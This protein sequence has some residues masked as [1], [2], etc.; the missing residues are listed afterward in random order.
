ME[1]RGMTVMTDESLVTAVTALHGRRGWHVEQ[2]M[3]IPPLTRLSVTG[4]AQQRL[5]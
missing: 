1:L 5:L 3:K 4:G 2:A